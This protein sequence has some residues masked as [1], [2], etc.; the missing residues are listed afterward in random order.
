MM[1]L[2]IVIDMD[3]EFCYLFIQFS[4]EENS[5]VSVD[6]AHQNVKKGSQCYKKICLLGPSIEILHVNFPGLWSVEMARAVS[7]FSNESFRG[8]VYKLSLA[9]SMAREELQDILQ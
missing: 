4:Q 5:H 6:L 8:A 3:F 7:Q 9:A 2:V 1:N